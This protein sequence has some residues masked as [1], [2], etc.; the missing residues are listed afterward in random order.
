MNCFGT[1]PVN[2]PGRR[3]VK[4]FEK[5]LTRLRPTVRLTNGNAYAIASGFFPQDVVD[6]GVNVEL[7]VKV[8]LR[9]KSCADIVCKLVYALSRFKRRDSGPHILPDR[10][11]RIVRRLVFKYGDCNY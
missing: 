4:T 2:V 6:R 1:A 11:A 10:F 7:G 8:F 5:P 3:V 9:F